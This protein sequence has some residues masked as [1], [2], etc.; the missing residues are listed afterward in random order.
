MV[1]LCSRFKISIT[2]TYYD[3]RVL[4][5]MLIMIRVAELITAYGRQ[6]LSKM[7]DT[8]RDLSFE[9]IYRDTDSLFLHNAPKESL[10]KFKDLF[11]RELDIEL[12]IN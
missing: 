6:T 9:I 1:Q 5:A 3:P 12:E 7:Q 11:N 8:A 10:S 4:V 2:N